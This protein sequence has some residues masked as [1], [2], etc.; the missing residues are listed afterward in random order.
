VNAIANSPEMKELQR[1]DGAQARP[2]GLDDLARQLRENL[3]VWKAIA[4]EKRIS[5]D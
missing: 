3:A 1:I 4:V 5:L 2:M